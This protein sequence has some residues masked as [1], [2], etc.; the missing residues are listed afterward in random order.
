MAVV[1]PFVGRIGHR[2]TERAGEPARMTVVS[3]F[4]GRIGHRVTE[5]AGEPA[6]MTAV[7]PFVGRIAV[8]IT[9]DASSPVRLGLDLDQ[10]ARMHQAGDGDH[11]GG[12]ADVAEDLAVDCGQVVRDR[13]I[14]DEH[15]R[16]DDVAQREPA[17]G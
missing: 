8:R 2:V 9:Q 11:R 12:R 3:P 14:H 16:P 1:S 13:H 6:R 17:L 15:A 10:Q 4:V 5:R 7:S